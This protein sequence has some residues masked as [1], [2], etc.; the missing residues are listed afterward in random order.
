MALADS[1]EPA[2]G[3]RVRAYQ[4]PSEEFTVVDT[5]ISFEEARERV[6]E[7]VVGVNGGGVLLESASRDRYVVVDGQWIR[8]A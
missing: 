8:E 3:D 7:P 1:P 4:F 5:D 6:D 2:V